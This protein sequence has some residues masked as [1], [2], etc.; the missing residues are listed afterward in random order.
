MSW[1]KEERAAYM[2]EYRKKN[3]D[4]IRVTFALW[5]QKNGAERNRRRRQRYRAHAAQAAGQSPAPSK[6][7]GRAVR[8]T[9]RKRRA[10][11]RKD[12]I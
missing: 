5:Y 11:S 8:I 4:W 12:K 2:R 9:E 1:T 3:R 7:C 6:L 10:G